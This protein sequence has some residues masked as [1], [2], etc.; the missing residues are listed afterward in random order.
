MP[1]IL[2]YIDKVIYADIDV[3][4][5][6]DLSEMYNI[7]FKKKTYFCATLDYHFMVNDVKKKFGIKLN[8]YIN[9]GILLINLKGIRED[10]IEKKIRHFI[11]THELRFPD[12]TAINVV[13]NNNIQILSYKYGLFAKD[14][15]SDLVNHNAQ[16]D[17]IYRFNESELKLAYKEPVFFHYFNGTKPFW[18]YNYNA[19]FSRVYWWYYA[20]MSGFYKNIIDYYNYTITE[21]EEFIKLIPEDGG[22]LRRNFKKIS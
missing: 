8:K 20:K 22:L 12:Q 17:S 3:I 4:N 10:G 16:Q 1:S 13:C 2:P 15:F 19:N 7:E 14:S 9:S 21:I 5:L 11:L 6:A 18:R